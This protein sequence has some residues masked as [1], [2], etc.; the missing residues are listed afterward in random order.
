MQRI[1]ASDFDIVRV[2][3]EGTPTIYNITFRGHA[4]ANTTDLEI[5]ELYRDF[6]LKCELRFEEIRDEAAGAPAAEHNN[7]HVTPHSNTGDEHL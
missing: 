5:A 2:E 6:Q 4:F 3:N 7:Q 1:Q